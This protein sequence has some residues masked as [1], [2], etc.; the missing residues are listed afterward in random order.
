[1]TSPIG[2]LIL[3]AILL[4]V[5]YYI[6]PTAPPPIRM[7]LNIVGWICI[8]VGVILLIALLLHIPIGSLA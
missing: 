2:L 6:P 8:V 7:L 4:I 5:S 3:G 1:M